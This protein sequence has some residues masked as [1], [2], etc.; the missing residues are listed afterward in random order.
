MLSVLLSAEMILQSHAPS[1]LSNLLSLPSPA[2]SP[3]ESTNG[4][5]CKLIEHGDRDVKEREKDENGFLRPDLRGEIK[6]H[7]VEC[8]GCSTETKRF[9]T[10]AARWNW[11]RHIDL[12]HSSKAAS[13]QAAPSDPA[14][15]QSLTEGSTKKSRDPQPAQ[16]Q[17]AQAA[18]CSAGCKGCGSCTRA[19]P[20][21]SRAAVQT[22][23]Q[24]VV[25]TVVQP[26]TQPNVQAAS[27]DVSMP[28]K[29][30]V[31]FQKEGVALFSKPPLPKPWRL[32]TR[33][34][35]LASEEAQKLK[36][37]IGSKKKQQ[38][39]SGTKKFSSRPST[40]PDS[41]SQVGQ[42]SSS[43]P[44]ISSLAGTNVSQSST[45]SSK[46]ASETR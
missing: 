40:N 33:A 35:L 28:Q 38:G 1:N 16:P 17:A 9:W 20:A 30:N 23:V 27:Q 8:L 21:R 42:Q 26:N 6:G 36:T 31:Q 19:K 25:Q 14:L 4:K 12:K 37:A 22:V 45:F 29:Q 11:N 46:S 34:N 2:E 43:V 18:R 32:Q 3:S 44:N 10:T 39:T 41:Q 5:V 24:H 15:P 13:Q 7:S